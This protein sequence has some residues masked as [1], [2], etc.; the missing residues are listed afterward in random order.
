MPKEKEHPWLKFVL[1]ILVL[2]VG[3]DSP[4]PLPDQPGKIGPVVVEP[5]TITLPLP[6]TRIS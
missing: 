2:I 4:Y 3:C 6:L 5:Q 1:G